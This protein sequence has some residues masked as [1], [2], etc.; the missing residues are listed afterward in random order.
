MVLNFDDGGA[1]RSSDLEES[2]DH[3]V[4]IWF[5]G[6]SESK[7]ARRSMVAS[8]CPLCGAE[9]YGLPLARRGDG[10]SCCPDTATAVAVREQP[11]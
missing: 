5:S 4:L 11:S 7:V 3:F 6:A 10:V 9:C 2:S 1:K 8:G